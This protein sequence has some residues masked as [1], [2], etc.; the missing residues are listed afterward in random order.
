MDF[1][2]LYSFY[3]LLSRSLLNQKNIPNLGRYSV[4]SQY[5]SHVYIA[6]SYNGVIYIFSSIRWQHTRSCGHLLWPTWPAST[7]G[8]ATDIKRSGSSSFFPRLNIYKLTFM[9]SF[10]LQLGSN[11]L[12]FFNQQLYSLLERINPD[13]N[14]P[15]R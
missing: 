7:S 4:T 11:I 9:W 13:H 1:R 15:V 10:F 6:H 8:K 14:F 12:V 3:S 5:N 2:S